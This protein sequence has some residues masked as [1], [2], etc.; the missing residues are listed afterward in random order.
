M[1]LISSPSKSQQ[2]VEIFKDRILKGLLSPGDRIQ[3]MRVLARELSVSKK[4]VECAFNIL[5]EDGLIIKEAGRRGTFVKSKLPVEQPD[6]EIRSRSVSNSVCMIMLEKGHVYENIFQGICPHLL[7]K[8]LY[9]LVISEEYYYSK[10]SI[11]AFL[12]KIIADKP[13]GFIVEGHDRLPYEFLKDMVDVTRNLVFINRYHWDSEIPGAKF[14]LADYEMAGESAVEHFFSHRHRNIA[15]ITTC[16]KEE[17]KLWK[18]IQLQMLNGF[19]RACR[20]R[21]MFFDEGTSWR[22]INGEPTEDVVRDLFSSSAPPTGLL[23]YRDIMAIE[24][25][26]PALEKMDLAVPRDVSIVG[27][28]NTPHSAGYKVPL[29]SISICEEEIAREAYRLLVGG[30]PG[31]KVLIK[32]KLVERESVARRR[33]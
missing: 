21:R 29:S 7:K 26:I 22:L 31:E 18:S 24:Q 15:F 2:V 13:Y 19:R 10:D 8:G 6:D 11:T 16:E 17:P 12:S 27:F 9:P 5:E 3:C 14:A 20:R 28:Y 1:E 23:V 33:A 32:P 4:V 25:L 30:K